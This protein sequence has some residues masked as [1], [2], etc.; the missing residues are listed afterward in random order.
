MRPATGF[1]ALTAILRASSSKWVFIA[2]FIDQPTILRENRSMITAR[3]NQPS[4]VLIYVMS[5][6]HFSFGRVA[7]K[8]L[9]S[10]FSA[11][12][13]EC[14]ESVVTRNFLLCT[15]QMRS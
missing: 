2:D 8:S 14:S 7:V 13:R 15:A 5:D 1:R 11:T 10:K 3:Y 12:G 9:A 4:L 6:T